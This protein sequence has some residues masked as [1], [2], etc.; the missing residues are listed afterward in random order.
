M[1]T[2][3]APFRATTVVLC[4][5]A[6][7]APLAAYNEKNSAAIG[8]GL[9]IIDPKTPRRVSIEQAEQL[10]RE[11]AA[12]FG[13]AP[14]STWLEPAKDK[15]LA[16]DAD[17]ERAIAEATQKGNVDR[18]LRLAVQAL[19]TRPADALFPARLGRAAAFL[20]LQERMQGK[21]GEDALADAIYGA[22][23]KFPADDVIHQA[24][25][26]MR[27]V[28]VGL[29]KEYAQAR[30]A[31]QEVLALP[32]VVTSLR[33]PA[34]A[35]AGAASEGMAD[36]EGAAAAFADFEKHAPVSPQYCTLLLRAVF[37]NLHLNRPPEAL[38]IIGVLEKTDPAVV[39]RANGAEQIQQFV[40]LK[41]S[42]KAEDYWKRWPDWWPA[43]EALAKVVALPDAAAETVVPAIAS[44]QAHVTAMAAAYQA[45]DRQRFLH[46]LRP[47]VSAAR[48][49]PEYAVRVSS[50]SL[51]G[52]TTERGVVLAHRDFLFAL[53]QKTQGNFGDER[54]ERARQRLLAAVLVDKQE[55]KQALAMITE[56]RSRTP[57]DDKDRSALHRV[58]ALAAERTATERE[59]AAAAIEEDL[60]SG[61]AIPLRGHSIVRLASLYR[62]MLK[63]DEERSLIARELANPELA[64]QSPAAYAALTARQRQLN[65]TGVA[66]RS[67]GIKQK[68]VPPPKPF[69]TAKDTMFP[70]GRTGGRSFEEDEPFALVKMD[71]EPKPIRRTMPPYPAELKARG[72]TGRVVVEFIVDP[73]GSVVSAKVLSSPDEA[74]S[75]IAIA[76]VSKWEFEPGRKDGQPVAV[77][78]QVPLVFAPGA[79]LPPGQPTPAVA[80]P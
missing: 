5:L 74:L 58:W 78:M 62:S 30:A 47:A 9:Q 51:T 61:D 3:P 55:P 2:T 46:E 14:L 6:L 79:A 70:T 24:G 20:E 73:K 19:V 39:A 12:A 69:G 28:H 65:A 63:F 56:L 16:T 38:R 57:P 33:A 45:K 4:A 10:H 64:T 42:G 36:Y 21:A 8:E 25:K 76:A 23:E 35:L 13:A 26:L 44:P 40:A 34:A 18:A 32:Q 49:L 17:F 11:I 77:R 43:W 60:R 15:E 68:I 53:L 48:W 75:A 67:P 27:G 29:K 66:A 80:A 31:A 52:I 59:E 22:M 37:L 50:F 1:K 41:N 72:V 7:A 71:A 54:S